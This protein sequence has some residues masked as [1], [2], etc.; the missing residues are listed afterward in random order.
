M[1]SKLKKTFC[2]L[3]LS[4]VFSNFFLTGCSIAVVL[5]TYALPGENTNHVCFEEYTESKEKSEI[6]NWLNLYVKYRKKDLITRLG[7]E[8][9]YLY[10]K[11]SKKFD[12]NNMK[13]KI[14]Y[15]VRSKYYN[16]NKE[17]IVNDLTLNGVTYRFKSLCIYV[18]NREPLDKIKELYQSGE[19]TEEEAMNWY[20]ND[21]RKFTSLQPVND[22]KNFSDMYLIKEITVKNIKKKINRYEVSQKLGFGSIPIRKG[23]TKEKFKIPKEVVN[24]KEGSDD[25]Q[26]GSF[27]IIGF[28]IFY[29]EETGKY[30]GSYNLCETDRNLYNNTYEE[31]L[32]NVDTIMEYDKALNAGCDISYMYL[33]KE[34]IVL[35]NASG[36]LRGI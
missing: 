4:F 27:S 22:Y 1:K 17:N 35:T 9:Y 34:K 6:C 25:Y 14:G 11:T 8:D 31:N 24:Y 21:R 23:Y 33:S 32:E 10:I 16:V 26:H 29:S 2:L 12:V 3:L 30:I 5:L 19:L 18:A 15:G 7:E 13:I 36:S 28:A 20:Q